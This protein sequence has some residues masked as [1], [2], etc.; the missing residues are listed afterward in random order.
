[1]REHWEEDIPKK[2]IWTPSI[3]EWKLMG[4]SVAGPMLALMKNLSYLTFKK[5]E[6]DF[7]F[8]ERSMPMSSTSMGFVTWSPFSLS[9]FWH[10]PV[11]LEIHPFLFLTLIMIIIELTSPPI[12]GVGMWFI[13]A[14]LS[15]SRGDIIQ[16][17]TL[18]E[19]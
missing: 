10:P 6:I 16:P 11:I 19:L 8:E 17:V 15:S 7:E 5:I 3:R 2:W 14:L 12:T 9:W 4:G 18:W 1:M 13:G